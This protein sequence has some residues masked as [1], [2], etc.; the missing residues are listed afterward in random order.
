MTGPR[1]AL[2]TF[3]IFIRPSAD[4]ANDGFH[5]RND[6]NLAAAECSEG[7]I[8]RSGYDGDPGPASWGP[9]RYP[10]FYSGEGHSPS[11]LSLWRDL[12]AP[13]AYAYSGIHAE[14]LS[15]GRDWFQ[16]PLAPPLK[17]AWPPYVLWWVAPG[18]VPDWQEAVERHEY[19][20]DHGASAHA[21][22]WKTPFDAEGRPASL[23][24]DALRRL[25][26]I[27]RERQVA[28]QA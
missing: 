13:Y 23:D 9:H 28:L 16:R 17:P 11:T 5:A 19:L 8:A 3:G 14:A 18:H 20:H 15:R 12:N 2:Y 22:D 6:I 1:L 26:A 24:R 27:N 21:F 4:P 25:T 10:R 7:F